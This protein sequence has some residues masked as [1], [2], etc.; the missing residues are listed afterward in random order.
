MADDLDHDP[1]APSAGGGQPLHHEDAAPL[2]DD[3]PVAGL[4]EGPGRLGRVLV[5]G[6]GVLGGE[7][8]ENAKRVNRLRNPPGQGQVHLAQPEHLHAL[9]QPGVARGTGGS[10]GV[11]RTGDP[12]AQG[13]LAGRVVGHRPRVVVVRPVPRVV[14]VLPD[15]GDLV[16]GLDCPVFG[17]P[18]INPDSGQIQVAQLEPGVSQGLVGT[19][20]GDR[21]RPGTS[22][23]LLGRLVS[24]L[25][26]AADPRRNGPHEPSFDRG[27]AGPA[28]QEISPHG[29]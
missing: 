11:V 7:T 14:V 17:H 5:D 28:G 9:D 8:R 26:V 20:D 15:S 27:D 2:R 4:V 18:E 21:P 3:D 12:R 19:V 1:G 10:D 22:A 29:A 25:V 24:P 13:H 6:Q 16:L 23:P